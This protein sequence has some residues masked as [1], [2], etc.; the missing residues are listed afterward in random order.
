MPSLDSLIYKLRRIQVLHVI[1]SEV[2]GKGRCPDGT[3]WTEGL[4]LNL[5]LELALGVWP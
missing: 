1:L 4:Y 3:V 5:Y 2:E